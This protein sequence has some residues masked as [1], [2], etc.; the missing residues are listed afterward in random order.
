MGGGLAYYSNESGERRIYLQTV[1]PS[2]GKWSISTAGGSMPRWSADGRELYW[3]TLDHQQLIAV[4]M[5][6]SGDAPVVGTPHRLFRAPFRR[7]TFGRNVFDQLDVS[8]SC[9]QH[10]A[11]PPVLGLFVSR[12]RSE[13]L[14]VVQLGKIDGQAQVA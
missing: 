6:T 10:E 14:V 9:G 12:H 11:Q 7:T 3:V 2:A 8:E 4:D 5:D 13:H 1:P